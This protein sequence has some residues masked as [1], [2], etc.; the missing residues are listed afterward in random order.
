MMTI[1]I[2]AFQKTPFS[3][4]RLAPLDPGSY[5]WKNDPWIF[6]EFLAQKKLV[7]IGDKDFRSFFRRKYKKVHY[8]SENE[9]NHSRFHLLNN[10][11]VNVTLHMSKANGKEQFCS[12]IF[13]EILVK[14]T[15]Q[16]LQIWFCVNLWKKLGDQ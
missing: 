6:S 2:R 12:K 4:N 13:H 14:M 7:E 1:P 9:W 11:N 8:V 16:L 10:H 15:S 3:S 5:P